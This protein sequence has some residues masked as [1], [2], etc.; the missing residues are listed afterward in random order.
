MVNENDI[1]KDVKSYLYLLQSYLKKHWMP[2]ILGVILGMIAEGCTLISPL[3]TKFLMD[4]VIIGKH[5]LYFKPLILFSILVLLVFLFTSLVANYILIKEFKLVAVKLK[6]DM[7][8]ALQYAPVNFYVK[9][10]IGG[11]S[12]RLL[13][14][15]EAL[16]SSWRNFLT[17]I[18][19]QFVLLISAVFMVKWNIMLALFAFVILAV[20]S[21]VI[22]RFRKPIMH[23]VNKVR[24]KSQEVN[25]YTVE[26]FRRIELVKALST[27][28]FERK[29]FFKKLQE[30]V[31]LEIKTF[32]ISK[33]SNVLQSLIS[34]IWSLTILFYGGM[35]VIHGKM[36]I[37]T[38]M[39]F[40][41]FTGILYR[42][43]ASFTN[44]IL[45]FQSV[46]VNLKRVKEYSEIKP[47]IVEKND[48]IEFIPEEGRINLENISFS[49][50]DKVVLSNINIEFL[51]N[52]ITAIVGPTGSGKTTL[53]K[54]LVR[55][56]DPNKGRILLDG[57]DIRDIKLSSLRKSVKL[58]L[59]DNHVFNGTL[60][61]NITYGVEYVTEDN[62]ELALKNAA[63]DFIYK[64][65]F[66]LNTVIGEG[67]INLSRGESERISL[68]R[69]FLLSP[70]VLIFDEPTSSVDMETE[71][72]INKAFLKLK[73][74]STVIIIT[75]R[76]SVA[77]I[78]D[79]IVVLEN[80]EVKGVG[81]HND[82]LTKNDFYKKVNKKV[83]NI[84]KQ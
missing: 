62:I 27:E 46:R 73:C 81:T 10:T 68:A 48:A 9:E 37:G 12:Y 29:N 35:L 65:P 53:A 61:E 33:F 75:H 83:N 18:P 19:M 2:I 31:K 69:A 52:S 56:F 57:V 22:S 26:H 15:T 49:Y 78:A 13:G 80:G 28:K 54:L 36:T 43:I 76:I 21:Y 16:V 58:F 14:D 84:L 44:L 59:S 4:F 63:V 64:L 23:Y 82:L 24:S 3:I 8:K 45:S 25:G 74:K 51:P 6:L 55:F 38:L 34:N 71:D 41:M 20:Q 7:F 39:A 17:T 67:G 1:V 30:L 79:R 32:M 77:K 72:R 50:G 47:E 66:G 60:Y 42:P 70:K 40:L 11:I 5:Y